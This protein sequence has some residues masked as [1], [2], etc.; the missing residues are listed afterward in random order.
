MDK[1]TFTFPDHDSLWQFKNQ[2]QAINVTITPKKNMI[3]GL[4]QQHDITLAVNKFNAITIDKVTSSSPSQDV[5]KTRQDWLKVYSMNYMDTVKRLKK[6]I[7]SIQP[8]K[9]F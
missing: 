5:R 4:F 8:L 1:M 9:L 3:S 7:N 2:T 6:V